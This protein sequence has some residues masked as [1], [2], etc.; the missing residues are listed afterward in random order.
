MVKVIIVHPIDDSYGAT[1]ILS[2]VVSALNNRFQ[3]EI[4][5]KDDCNHI[6]ALILQQGVETEKVC[7]KKV[8]E[9]PIIHSKVLTAKGVYSL[10][11]DATKFCILLSKYRSENLV[12]YINTY[13]AGLVSLA[14]KI[15]GIKNIVHCHE[16]QSHKVL[17]RM[18]ASLVIRTADTIICVSKVVKQY[19]DGGKLSSNSVVIMNGI[20]DVF[21]DQVINKKTDI[22]KV[23][24]LIVGRVM[25]EKGYWFLAQAVE[26]LKRE[27]NVSITVDCFGD[28]PP[29]RPYL[30][31][32]FREY[33]KS[34]DLENEVILHGFSSNADIEMV[35]YDVVLVPS[36][37][38]DPFP[39]TVLE[40]MRAQSLVIA[41]DHGGAAE[42]ID[43]GTNGILIKKDDIRGLKN[44]L[45]ALISH[46]IDICYLSKNGRSFYERCL[47]D[48][49]FEKNI[50]SLFDSFLKD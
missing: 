36:I 49:A 44:V 13:A 46:Q 23:K 47:T 29:N 38:S 2:Y 8:K 48:K 30:L 43:H 5:F 42:I 20:K 39:T 19:V 32:D 11:K 26:M 28:A 37:M 33:L 6:K 15:Y 25:P 12:F 14:C 17:G 31:D 40:A 3:V 34:L 10:A 27:D 22:E 35:N 4:W 1:K 41:T 24:F 16:N 45:S 18:L 7:F 9:I 50:I 21:C